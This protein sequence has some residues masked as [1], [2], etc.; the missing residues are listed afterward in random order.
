MQ[1]KH[2]NAQAC[3]HIVRV[4]IMQAG[5]LHPNTAVMWGS[6]CNHVCTGVH[7]HTRVP[8]TSSPTSPQA[9]SPPQPHPHPSYAIIGNQGIQAQRI[10]FW[11]HAV[12]QVPLQE[13]SAPFQSVAGGAVEAGVIVQFL[14]STGSKY[15]A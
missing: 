11:R 15:P 10:G 14:G 8:F 2:T 6:A 3:C 5:G 4:Q 13:I 1:H 7:T 9:V 12:A